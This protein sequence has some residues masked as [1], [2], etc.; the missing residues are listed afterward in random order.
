MPEVSLKYQIGP[1]IE[2][3]GRS[4]WLPRGMTVI[5]FGVPASPGMFLGGIFQKWA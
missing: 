2:F 3:L 4:V 1:F 5:T